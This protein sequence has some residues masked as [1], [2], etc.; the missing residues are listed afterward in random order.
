MHYVGVWCVL[1][2]GMGWDAMRCY[3]ILCYVVML[4]DEMLCT[5]HVKLCLCLR[6]CLCDVYVMFM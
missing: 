4:C 5:C 2:D 6:L 3:V 1:C